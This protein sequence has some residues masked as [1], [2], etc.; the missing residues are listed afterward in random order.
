M[1]FLR[2]L[3]ETGSPAASV[4]QAA[5]VEAPVAPRELADGIQL[6]RRR[7][8]V[9]EGR[10]RFGFGRL[11]LRGLGDARLHEGLAVR[12]VYQRQSLFH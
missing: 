10:R 3:L 2:W 4:R 5:L 7:V 11:W 1:S 6:L 9:V 8:A 12:R